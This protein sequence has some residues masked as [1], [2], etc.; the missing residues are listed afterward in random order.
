M[1]LCNEAVFTLKCPCVA[2]LQVIHILTSS[3]ELMDLI[4]NVD[5][6]FHLKASESSKSKLAALS[7]YIPTI[8]QQL[9]VLFSF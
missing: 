2:C 5:T 6:V 4:K 1:S 7:R 8:R 9:Q 3:V